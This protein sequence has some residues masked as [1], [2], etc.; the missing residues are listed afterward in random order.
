MAHLILGVLGALQVTWTDGSTAK[1]ETDKTRALLAYLAVEADGPHRRDALVG[2][3]W[4]DESEQTARHNLR[5][6]LYSLRQTLGDSAA[7]PPYLHI[8]R[9]E[10]Q[11]NT[12]S[13]HALDVA[14]FNAHLAATA[15]HTHARLD[16]CAVC[17]VRLQHAVGLYRGKF[18]QEFFLEDSAEF[19]EWA[20]ARREMLHQR[21]LDALGDLAHYYE[22]RG[23]LGA[24]RRC[25]F[26]QLEL[27]PWREPAH[28]QLMRVL[29]LE[30]QLGAAIAQYETC[31]RV[32]AE[33]LG[34]EP[35]SETRELYERIRTGNWKLEVGDLKQPARESSNFQLPTSNLPT[36]LTPFIGRERE[37]A[38]LGRLIADPACRCITLVGPGGIGK[39]RLALQVASVHRNVFAQGAAF[40]PLVA[41]DSVEVM[42][43]AIA[44][45]LGFSFYGPTS[46]RVQLLNYLRDKQMLLVLDNVEH[47]LAADPLQGNAADL[48]IKILGHA[49]D[50]KLLVTA[51]EPLNV[52]GEWVFEVEGLQIPEGDGIAAIESAAAGALFLQR[53]RQAHV[54]FNA[55]PEDCLAILRICRLVDGMPLGI[56]LAAAWVRTLAC[57]EIAWEIE[58]GLDFLRVSTRDLPA[59]HRSMRAV[60]DQ[61]W[62]LL[63]EE[64]QTVLLRL[65]VFRG[66][67]RRG[68]AEVVAEATLSVL[69]TL[70]TKSLIRRSAV[71]RYDLH[72]L[73][74]QFG[75]EQ[76][77]ERPEE[78]AAT[79][80]RH[81]SYYMMFFS[82]ADGRLRSSAQREALAELTAEMDNFRA[83]WDWAVTHG[84]FALIEQTM[85]LFVWF[86]DTR[87][88]FQEG[89]D[90]LGRAVG[91]LETSHEHSA[92]NRADQVALG[93]ILASR[94]W[95]AYRLA[96]Y[97]QAQA[98]LERS[99]EILRPLNEPRALVK[100]LYF[101]GTVMEVTGN[102]SRALE[103]YSEGLEVATAIGDQWYTALCSINLNG[104]AAITH[105][106]VK[107]ENAHERLQS[108]VAD[109]RLIGDPRLTAFGLRILSQSAFTLGRY[110]EAR[111]ALEESAALNSSVGFG[112]GLGAAYRGLGIVA[113]AQGEHQ[114]A[115]DMFRKSLDTFIELGGRWWVA[116]VL[117]EMSR[118]VFALGNDAEAE[119]GWREALRIAMETR[120]TPVALEA[121][122]GFASVLAKRRN[123]EDALELLL[124]VSNHP[125]S[126][127]ETKDRTAGLRAELEAQLTSQQVEAAQ[128]RATAQTFEA[129]VDKILEQAEIT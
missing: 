122:A 97:E 69:S 59:R 108:T 96:H 110:A 105:V 52:Q 103:L 31:S 51:R 5:Q 56:E 2:L 23:D 95:L 73:I 7:Q 128:G 53:A 38:D 115:V 72:E 82:Q 17:A 48:F 117:A 44:E 84:E 61:S 40:V 63:S 102:Y 34:V 71:G 20:L 29:A 26:R 124:M 126:F 107:S 106:I 42:V 109:C 24:S 118:S 91:A 127:Q 74:R 125:A 101:L 41:I 77:A 114:Q 11:F 18:L 8:T 89:L 93:H 116:R 123:M 76:F 43:P 112:W 45:A 100:S 25:A 15:S 90:T 83:S 39:T 68:A 64:E 1:F 120:G 65:S 119:R 50:I 80:A 14:S 57:D 54:G 19:E 13:D 70:V 121:L 87:G 4:P 129:V 46:P 9:D 37:L 36:P 30:G 16:A 88:W 78:Q 92:P 21:A 75:A 113:Q 98:M 62:K 27:D 47:L 22:Q 81:G 3:L 67:F 58:R 10:I 33:E 111:A 55:T 85:R 66:G 32:L 60:F 49:M 86:Y 35:S 79:Q 99:L 28:R 12:A 104:L 6:A 94:S